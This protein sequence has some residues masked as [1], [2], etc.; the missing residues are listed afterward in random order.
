MNSQQSQDELLNILRLIQLLC[1]NCHQGF[2]DYLRNQ[3]ENSDDALF[4]PL[5]TVNLVSEV[6][7]VLIKL[8]EKL[9]KTIFTDYIV[10]NY[11]SLPFSSMKRLAKYSTL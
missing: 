11:S 8:T 7:M 10:S 6:A 4:T 3:E 9:G 2:Q 1:D 5:T